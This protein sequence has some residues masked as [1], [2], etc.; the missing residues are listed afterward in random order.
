[1]VTGDRVY[2]KGALV[3]GGIR[4]RHAQIGGDFIA[5]GAAVISRRYAQDVCLSSEQ[6]CIRCLKKLQGSIDQAIRGGWEAVREKLECYKEK[7]ELHAYNPDELA[8]DAVHLH[9]AHIQG[10]VEL[11]DGF[12][13]IG[14]VSLN[15][16]QVDGGVYCRGGRFLQH[17][18]VALSIDAINV[19]GSVYLDEYVERRPGGD[20]PGVGF[21]AHGTVSMRGANIKHRLVIAKAVFVK[22][23]PPTDKGS[24]HPHEDSILRERERYAFFAK[25]LQVAGDVFFNKDAES[26]VGA[27]KQFDATGRICLENA[28]IGGRLFLAARP[29][30]LPM[31]T[32]RVLLI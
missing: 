16:A 24:L 22:G 1:M 32:I 30:I 10:A 26:G 21:V 14:E 19:A 2:L 25:R 7:Q 12:L 3:R 15:S 29:L 8:V 23:L 17:D 31:S 28:D 11:T 13:S 20:R 4:L 6:Q 18:G 5:K 9:Q 27:Y